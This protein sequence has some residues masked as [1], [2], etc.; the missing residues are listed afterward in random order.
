MRPLGTGSRFTL[1]WALA[2]LGLVAGCRSSGIDPSGEHVF[3]QPPLSCLQPNP[4]SAPAIAP[5]VAQSAPAYREYPGNQLP[6]D[7]VRVIVN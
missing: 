1:A 4:P 6:W 3:N 7:N 5:P 2:C